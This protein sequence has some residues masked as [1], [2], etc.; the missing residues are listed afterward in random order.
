[1]NTNR[2]NILVG[3]LLITFF[4]ELWAPATSGSTLSGANF[5]L[6][7]RIAYF[8][9]SLVILLAMLICRKT[10]IKAYNVFL[11][12]T[13]LVYFFIQKYGYL[14]VHQPVRRLFCFAR[15][16][17]LQTDEIKAESYRWIKCLI[18]IM[19]LTGIVCYLSFIFDLGLPYKQMPYYSLIKSGVWYLNYHVSYFYMN[20]VQV[21]LCGLFNEPGWFGTF[22]A[23]CLCVE[24]LNMRK[25]SNIIILIA[26]ILTF[27]LAFI[28]IIVLY[29]VLK[30]ITDW[31]KW[32]WLVL[33]VSL[34]LFV[35]PN[36]H[37]GNEIIDSFIGRIVLT[38]ESTQNSRTTN[39]FDTMFEAFLRRPRYYM[40]TRCRILT[41]AWGGNLSI[42]TDIV[43][44]GILGVLAFL[45]A[46]INF[47]YIPGS[48]KQKGSVLFTLYRSE[49][50]SASMAF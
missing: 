14:I 15:F 6:I 36:V 45:C 7:I 21:R 4:L 38:A 46:H 26:G 27:S 37:T 28:L 39:A 3:V 18:V 20:A 47:T 11:A 16:F 50:I 42:K 35:L 17:A 9:M 13:P 31:R 43:D 19:S 48:E 2:K 33:L 32:V 49:F 5:K 29:F 23:F 40:G 8:S 25:L 12:I 30:N 10:E 34:Y 22:L 44:F 41:I 1:M 24:D